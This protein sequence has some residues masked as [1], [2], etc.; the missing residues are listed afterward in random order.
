[1]IVKWI[2]NQLSSCPAS[3]SLLPYVFLNSLF[4]TLAAFL[5]VTLGTVDD[6]S[7]SCFNLIPFFFSPSCS[8]EAS[9]LS[10]CPLMAFFCSTVFLASLVEPLLDFF[11]FF[12]LVFVL[13]TPAA[14]RDGTLRPAQRPGAPP[15]ARPG[16]PAGG[17]A[18][19]GRPCTG[20]RARPHLRQGL[21]WVWHRNTISSCKVS[22]LSLIDLK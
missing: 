6:D 7:I 16:S 21:V 3:V 10:L 14:A 4:P 1:M 5:E 2:S 13:T 17:A 15:G 20:P 9:I 8:A 19:G 11:S 18:R 12:S 22:W